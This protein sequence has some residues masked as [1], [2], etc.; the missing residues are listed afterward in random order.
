MIEWGVEQRF[1][2]SAY[3]TRGRLVKNAEAFGL[4]IAPTIIWVKADSRWISETSLVHELVHVALWAKNGTPD[5][6]HEGH[7]VKGW[8]PKHT[9]FIA[10]VNRKL[11]LLN[12]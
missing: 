11:A 2:A 1:V 9:G 5:P 3:D 4:A 7:Q 12:H 6:D 10:R 8:T